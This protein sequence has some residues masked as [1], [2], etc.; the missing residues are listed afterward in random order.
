MD[1]APMTLGPVLSPRKYLAQR[2]AIAALRLTDQAVAPH[3]LRGRAPDWLDDYVRG[4]LLLRDM[5][6]TLD[7][8]KVLL[9]PFAISLGVPLPHF[10]EL[11]QEVANY[12]DQEKCDLL[13]RLPNLLAK[14]EEVVCFMCDM[15]CQ[16]GEK[17]PFEGE[18]MELWRDVATGLFLLVGGRMA[19]LECLAS[20]IA[21][22]GGINQDEKFGGLPRALLLH[23]LDPLQAAMECESSVTEERQPLPAKPGQYLVIDLSGGHN[24]SHYP[25]RYT[26]EAPNVIDDT[27]LWLRRIPAGSFMMGSPK[28]ELGRYDSEVQHRVTLTRDYYIGIIPCTQ[29]QYELVTG[30]NPSN[31]KGGD[32]PVEQVTYNDLRGTD[33]GSRWPASS[34]V[35][36]GSFFGRLRERTGL[37]FDLPTEAQWEHACRAGTTTALNSGKDITSKSGRCPNLDAVAWYSDNSGHTTHPVGQKQPNA[38]GLYDMHGNVWEWCLDW[39]GAY[40]TADATDPQ[41]DSQ[42]SY[43]V[44]RGGGWGS[45]ARY[46]RSAYR[47]YGNPSLRYGYYGFRV[48]FRP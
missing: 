39:Y 29:R 27:E 21:S 43:L 11:K 24:A 1:T 37:A 7:E 44:G 33:R 46:C 38:W 14:A 20:R 22:G 45:S 3:P 10:E 19:V 4:Q 8:A 17:F 26:D 48:A 36:S 6:E 13:D 41:G 25:V 5:G 31:F 35:D 2:R 16:H 42:G 18:F 28:S 32:L 15:V 34:D 12:G 30:G 40:P 23:Y 47:G 9:R